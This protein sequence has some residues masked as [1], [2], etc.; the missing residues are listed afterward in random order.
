MRDIKLQSY[1]LRPM[2]YSYFFLFVLVACY[3]L[4]SIP[5]LEYLIPVY[6]IGIPFALQRKIHFRFNPRHLLAALAVSAVTVIPLWYIIS[7]SPLVF[8][9]VNTVVF[10]AVGVALPEEVFFRGFMQEQMGN[11]PRSL[12]VASILFAVIHLPRFV[13]YGD[14]FALMTFFPSLIMGFLYLMTSNVLPSAV[15]HFI[16]NLVILGL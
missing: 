3:H 4:L 9:S 5:L 10:Q 16:A 11:T 7:G 2:M 12:V 13:V 14:I 8:L 6:L 1:R 15:F